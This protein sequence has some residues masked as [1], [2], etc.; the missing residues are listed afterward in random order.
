[1]AVDVAD[2]LAPVS[3]DNPVGEDLSYDSERQ[4]I[5]MAFDTSFNDDDE[6]ADE[7]DWRAIIRLIEAQSAQTK[8][9]WL[10]VYLCRAGARARQIDTVARG[11]Q[12]LGGLLEQ[13]W[14]T[15]HPAL[16]ELGFQGRKGPCEGLTRRGEFI[17]PLR[18]IP[19]LRHPRLGEYSGADFERFAA[20]SAEDGYGMFRAA[21]EDAGTE[22]LAEVIGHLDEI[23]DGIRRA[24]A[25]L[26][27]NAD[28]D[29]GTNFTPVYE[30]LAAMRAAIDQFA[31]GPDV[32]EAA[33]DEEAAGAVP[34]AATAARGGGRGFQAGQIE[35]RDQVLAAMD[36]ISDYY[37]KYEPVSPVPLALARARDWVT[38]DFM[39]VIADIAPN[40][41]DDFKRVLLANKPEEEASSSW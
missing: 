10:P 20:S 4:T 28:G 24:D 15:V 40:G 17:L 38:A 37:R 12:Y 35:T 18:R 29:T 9:V 13:Y 25:V 26:V 39:A 1:M 7:T 5:E 36:A 2:L 31:G 19:L 14:A 30:A 11:A 6:G 34:G 21:I 27:A 33:A 16:D 22:A 32:A 23:R 3:D 41:M 8:D